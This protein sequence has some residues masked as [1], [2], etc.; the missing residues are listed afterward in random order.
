[1]K[2]I[3]LALAF[4]CASAFAADPAL[5][6]FTL[7]K[8]NGNAVLT[9]DV[10]TRNGETNLVRNTVVRNGVLESRNHKFYQDGMLVGAHWSYPDSNGFITEAN[11]PYSMIFQSSPSNIVSAAYICSPE[12]IVIDYF[13]ATNG[14]FYPVD[15][16]A[17]QE[18]RQMTTEIQKQVSPAPQ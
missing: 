5:R 10:F 11:S 4:S 18:A 7:V 1:M 13:T 8:T 17:V 9:L 16:S 2:A 15:T 12:R 6:Q 14:V 3:V